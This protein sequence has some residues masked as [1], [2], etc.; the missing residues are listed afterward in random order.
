MLWQV[1]VSCCRQMATY[2]PLVSCIEALA[3]IQMWHLV[4]LGDFMETVVQ[5]MLAFNNDCMAMAA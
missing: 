2:T 3:E 5:Y 4:S 1:G